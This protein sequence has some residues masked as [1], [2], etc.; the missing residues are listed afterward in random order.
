MYTRHPILKAIALCVVISFFMT[1]LGMTPEAF[2][3]LGV[4]TTDVPSLTAGTLA[5][6]AELG[7][8]TDSVTGDPSA[9]T[10]IH[11]QSA[12]GNYQAEKNIEKL[13]EHI[14]KNSAVRLMLLEGASSKLQPELFRIFPKAP[15][16]N[17]KVTDKLVQEGY[18]T[19]PERFLIENAYG[20]RSTEYGEQNKE[21]GVRNAANIKAEARDAARKTPYAELRTPSAV[22]FDAFGIED[23][24]SYKKDREAFIATVKSGK[25]AENYLQELRVAVDKRFAGKLN[26]DLL[27]LVRQEEA[28]DSGSLSFES[29]LKTLSEASRKH[30]RVDL[31]DA[32]YQDPYPYLIRYDRLQAIGSKIDREK[33]LGEMAGFLNELEKKGI[34]Q[35]VI[36]AFRDGEPGKAENKAESRNA[37]LRTPYSV[38]ASGY[39]PLRH[40]FDAAFE[41]LPKDFSIKA[42]PAWT[43]YA[44][45]VILMQEMEG[46]GLFAEVATLKAKIQETLAKTPEEK[47]YLDAARKLYLLKRLFNLELTRAE[48]EELVT[49]SE[50]RISRLETISNDRKSNDRNKRVSDLKDSGFEFVSDFGIRDSNL[51]EL[52]LLAM[53]FYQTAVIREEHMFSN[54]LKR[55]EELKEKRAIIVTGGFHAE[56]FKQLAAAKGCSYLQITPRIMEVTKRDHEVYL[57]AMLGARQFESSQIQAL[58]GTAAAEELLDVMGVPDL[59]NYMRGVSEITSREI[60]SVPYNQ[61]ILNAFAVWKAVHASSFQGVVSLPAIANLSPQGIGR[62]R[63]SAEAQQAPPPS[64]APSR[65]TDSNAGSSGALALFGGR[66]K[67]SSAALVLFT[68]PV[69]SLLPSFSQYANMTTALRALSKAYQQ[70]LRTH[71]NESTMRSEVRE[72]SSASGSELLALRMQIGAAQAKRAKILAGTKWYQLFA[73]HRAL[74]DLDRTMKFFFHLISR[75]TSQAAPT[76]VAG[77]AQTIGPRKSESGHAQMETYLAIAIASLSIT[78]FSTTHL[79]H[80]LAKEHLV[81]TILGLV[82]GFVGILL[83]VVISLSAPRSTP[84]RSTPLVREEHAARIGELHQL[85]G[86]YT[87][88]ALV[89]DVDHREISAQFSSGGKPWDPIPEAPV[90]LTDQPNE[91]LKR[92]FSSQGIML[93]INW[94]DFKSGQVYYFFGTPGDLERGERL[95]TVEDQTTMKS[96]AKALSGHSENPVLPKLR[97]RQLQEAAGD[98]ASG[99]FEEAASAVEAIAQEIQGTS[100]EEFQIIGTALREILVEIRILSRSSATAHEPGE[101]HRSEI[102]SGREVREHPGAMGNAQGATSKS[103]SLSLPAVQAAV[104][105][106]HARSNA[107]NIMPH[108]WLND[109]YTGIHRADSW[110]NTWSI[111]NNLEHDHSSVLGARNNTQGLVWYAAMKRIEEI[112]PDQ[113]VHVRI[114]L[115]HGIVAEIPVHQDTFKGALAASLYRYL[116]SWAYNL[117][118]IYGSENFGFGADRPEFLEIDRLKTLLEGDKAAFSDVLSTRDP[119]QLKKD[120]PRNGLPKYAN[121]GEPVHVMPIEEMPAM[122]VSAPVAETVNTGS[123]DED[124]DSVYIGADIGGR[125]AKIGV[126]NHEGI[127]ALNKALATMETKTALPES[128]AEFVQR[129]IERLKTIQAQ[130]GKKIRGVGIGIPGAID[131]AHDRPVT[132]GQLENEKG[133]S[134]QDIDQLA[135]M[136]E[137]ISKALGIPRDH[138]IIRNDM[139]PITTAVAANLDKM[140][141]KFADRSKGNFMINWMGSGHGFEISK[142]SAPIP[143]PTEAGHV[144]A[145][146]GKD[147]EPLFDTEGLTSITNLINE[148]RKP[149]WSVP[150]DDLRPLGKAAHD[151]NDPYHAVAIDILQNVFMK[152]FVQNMLMVHLLTAHAGVA[153]TP[154]VLVGGGVTRDPKA[155]ML[156]KLMDE[157]LKQLGLENDLGVHFLTDT[158][159]EAVVKDHSDLGKIGAAYLIRRHIA[160]LS[161]RSEARGM[162]LVDRGLGLM[163][164][165]SQTRTTLHEPL[166]EAVRPELRLTPDIEGLLTL[167]AL[168]L[169]LRVAWWTRRLNDRHEENLRLR[170]DAPGP[171]REPG[172][173]DQFTGHLF[174]IAATLAIEG[175]LLAAARFKLQSGAW[176]RHEEIMSDRGAKVTMVEPRES[177]GFNQKAAILVSTEDGIRGF[178]NAVFEVRDPAEGSR[179]EMRLG[180]GIF[181]IARSFLFRGGFFARQW[182]DERRIEKSIWASDVEDLW[183]KVSTEGPLNTQ[184]A[185]SI[186]REHLRWKLGNAKALVFEIGRKLHRAGIRIGTFR[187]LIE[188]VP[189]EHNS[190]TGGNTEAVKINQE[191]HVYSYPDTKALE[192]ISHDVSGALENMFNLIVWGPLVRVSFERQTARTKHPSRENDVELYADLRP[193]EETKI[194]TWKVVKEVEKLGGDMRDVRKLL[195]VLR[196]YGTALIPGTDTETGERVIERHSFPSATQIRQFLRDLPAHFKRSK[197]STASQGALSALSP[198]SKNSQDVGRKPQAE[199]APIPRRDDR[200]SEVRTTVDVGMDQEVR[201]IEDVYVKVVARNDRTERQPPQYVIQI[202]PARSTWKFI[203][204][205]NL[206]I[207]TK[208]SSPMVTVH[209]SG[210]ETFGLTLSGKHPMDFLVTFTVVKPLKSFRFTVSRSELRTGSNEKGKVVL[211]LVDA[212]TRLAARIA[213]ASTSFYVTKNQVPAIQTRLRE[214]HEQVIAVQRVPP[215][216]WGWKMLIGNEEVYRYF[217]RG[218]PTQMKAIDLDELKVLMATGLPDA[219]QEKFLKAKLIELNK[220]ASWQVPEFEEEFQEFLALERIPGKNFLEQGAPPNINIPALMAFLLRQAVSPATPASV[221][222]PA[223]VASTTQASNPVTQTPKLPAAPATSPITTNQLPP[224]TM[225]PAVPAKTPAPV[226]VVTPTV[227]APVVEAPRS[228]KAPVAPA[229]LQIKRL[230]EEWIPIKNESVL[231]KLPIGAKI[232]MRLADSVTL[233]V[234]SWNDFIAAYPDRMGIPSKPYAAVVINETGTVAEPL[235]EGEI[236]LLGRQPNGESGRVPFAAEFNGAEALSRR[237]LTLQVTSQGL[238]FTD[239]STYGTDLNRTAL[240]PVADAASEPVVGH[241][242][243]RTEEPRSVASEPAIP[244]TVSTAKTPKEIFENLIE[245]AYARGLAVNRNAPKGPAFSYEGKTIQ[246]QNGNTLVVMNVRVKEEGIEGESDKEGVEFA[247]AV[248][249]PEGG[250][251]R[252]KNWTGER[253]FSFVGTG[254]LASM[255]L[256]EK[257]EI[258]ATVSPLFMKRY[259]QKLAWWTLGGLLSFTPWKQDLPVTLKTSSRSEARAGRSNDV[260]RT[261]RGMEL[262]EV[263]DQRRLSDGSTLKVLNFTMPRPEGYEAPL[264]PARRRSV[265]FEYRPDEHS[266]PQELTAVSNQP[267]LLGDHVLTVAHTNLD[268]GLNA[269]V[270]ATVKL[271]RGISVTKIGPRTNIRKGDVLQRLGTITETPTISLRD[272]L[273][274][275]QMGGNDIDVSG[276]DIRYDSIPAGGVVT[277]A[278]TPLFTLIDRTLIQKDSGERLSPMAFFATLGYWKEIKAALRAFAKKGGNEARTGRLVNSLVNGYMSAEFLEAAEAKSF[279]MRSLI[280]DLIN[281]LTEGQFTAA[282]A[283]ANGQLDMKQDPTGDLMIELDAAEAQAPAPG[284]TAGSQQPS[285][286]NRGQKTRSESRSSPNKVFSMSEATGRLFQDGFFSGLVLAAADMV[287]VMVA[288]KIGN[289]FVSIKAFHEFS[290]PDPLSYHRYPIAVLAGITSV[291]DGEGNSM[292]VPLPQRLGVGLMENGPFVV[293]HIARALLAEKNLLEALRTGLINA[294]DEA[295]LKRTLFPEIL[296]TVSEVAG[297]DFFYLIAHRDV[298]WKALDIDFNSGLVY[299][300]VEQQYGIKFSAAELAQMTTPQELVNVT[301]QALASKGARSE[302]RASKKEAAEKA[303]IQK[304]LGTLQGSFAIDSLE[305]KHVELLQTGLEAGTFDSRQAKAKVWEMMQMTYYLSYLEG[306]WDAKRRNLLGVAKQIVGSQIQEPTFYDLITDLEVIASETPHALYGLNDDFT[307]DVRLFTMPFTEAVAAVLMNVSN[308]EPVFKDNHKV[309]A[310]VAHIQALDKWYRGFNPQVS[311]RQTR[312]EARIQTTDHRLPTIDLK[313][314]VSLQSPVSGLRF[315]ESRS[316]VRVA[317]TTPPAY[318]GP[319]VVKGSEVMAQVMKFLPVTLP[320]IFDSGTN[321]VLYLN[322]SLNGRLARQE[323]KRHVSVMI[324][325]SNNRPDI[326]SYLQRQGIRLDEAASYRIALS[327]QPESIDVTLYLTDINTPEREA[328]AQ[329]AIREIENPNWKDIEYLWFDY[330]AGMVQYRTSKAKGWDD[331]EHPN[332]SAAVRLVKGMQ[333]P[334][335]VTVENPSKI[336]A[337]ETA[338][339]ELAFILANPRM[340]ADTIMER[341]L[342]RN[343][344]AVAWNELTAAYTGRRG[345]DMNSIISIVVQTREAANKAPWPLQLIPAESLALGLTSQSRSEA[346]AAGVEKWEQLTHSVPASVPLQ[347][348]TEIVLSLAGLVSLEVLLWDDF[349]KKYPNLAVGVSPVQAVVTNGKDL[350]PLTDQP[351]SLGVETPGKFSD[352]I[353]NPITGDGTYFLSKQHVILKLEQTNLVLIDTSTSGTQWGSAALIAQSAEEKTS[354]LAKPTDTAVPTL[355]QTSDFATSLP[356][357]S[358]SGSV[359]AGIAAQS[360]TLKATAQLAVQEANALPSQT[361][362]LPAPTTKPA[363]QIESAQA[364]LAAFFKSLFEGAKVKYGEEHVSQPSP[365]EGAKWLAAISL[366]GK[367]PEAP[368]FMGFVLTTEEI[369]YRNMSPKGSMI[370]QAGLQESELVYIDDLGNSHRLAAYKD[371]FPVMAFAVHRNTR[372]MVIVDWSGIFSAEKYGS[373]QTPG[374]ISGFATFIKFDA[375]RQDQQLDD[376]HRQYS[377]LGELTSTLPSIPR[378][379]L[380]EAPGTHPEKLG[381]PMNERATAAVQPQTPSVVRIPGLP[382]VAQLAKEPQQL[383]QTIAREAAQPLA[384][385]GNSGAAAKPAASAAQMN[386]VPTGTSGLTLAKPAQ[387]KAHGTRAAGAPVVDDEGNVVAPKTSEKRGFK[388]FFRARSEVRGQTVGSEEYLSVMSPLAEAIGSFTASPNTL[389]GRVRS[390]LRYYNET[391]NVP[392]LS[393]ARHL[394]PAALRAALKVSSVVVNNVTEFLSRPVY[395]AAFFPERANGIVTMSAASAEQSRRAARMALAISPS[396]MDKVLDVFILGKIAEDP[397]VL[398]G[399]CQAYPNVTVVKIVKTQEQRSELRKLNLLLAA[400]GLAPVLAADP[401]NP[402]E[403]RAL[404]RTLRSRG[405]PQVTGLFKGS[406]IVP[407]KLKNLIPYIKV[408]TQRMIDNFRNAVASLVSSLL[409]TLRATAKSA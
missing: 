304:V 26:K 298:T 18:L 44:Q 254:A 191:S 151:E 285:N 317:E 283:I 19:G 81:W 177:L 178:M 354:Q 230:T 145:E 359:N 338:M 397:V 381:V 377:V 217:K 71:G 263:G 21:Y 23:L 6:P 169:L 290:G 160:E 30:L 195:L 260:Q 212:L 75:G 142:N 363:P 323:D 62:I 125:T 343:D 216:W 130:N 229:A 35:E 82:A 404:L 128:G 352:D 42:W 11:I 364:M 16:F 133:W 126:I 331:R 102:R 66:G 342:W 138:V 300:P 340:I 372:D 242:N 248:F 79:F 119:S 296:R 255:N 215:T 164:N 46:K 282:I 246:L 205:T 269:A 276:P 185:E 17:R 78:L 297:L 334:V 31:S 251:L 365:A 309:T 391:V 147:G 86:G 209:Q 74:F 387:V 249:T 155:K 369:E 156:Q 22:Q 165:E 181:T 408:V 337:S 168:G 385:T 239:T 153:D 407:E 294:S 56:G 98:V 382:Q 12:H 224:T 383:E 219:T 265:T 313:P 132:V 99:R 52:I 324:H 350:M 58:L 89:H 4:P 409:Q 271:Q 190:V 54:A 179:S 258:E 374:V 161:G 40:A 252:T 280:P 376:N 281:K 84:M 61:P 277:H 256:G 136:A 306:T 76:P 107:V 295:S 406:E 244:Q 175:I 59:R 270:L 208:T 348:G 122:T 184:H 57:N 157:Q 279:L 360:K 235:N 144:V 25:N 238:V 366:N 379:S 199:S 380:P 241:S 247:V 245:Q 63:P 388:K 335:I 72:D 39:S 266:K 117:G 389:H 344:E 101:P 349:L 65:P 200:R 159:I 192:A 110:S 13:L 189:L 14:E 202:K 401:E 187:M 43:L 105:R 373:E 50:K 211:E 287:V 69:S 356:L 173:F 182:L 108:A 163:G 394:S 330:S 316:E 166:G 240:N 268:R 34:A 186:D 139:E 400:N 231:V 90:I 275:F 174:L 293:G 288:Q 5:I 97:R 196:P 250:E 274:M 123:L 358:A 307:E 328:A 395:V 308:S 402:G 390:E 378:I 339:L 92:M 303:R 273:K 253:S 319:F 367:A 188:D 38:Q 218:I 222:A 143:M 87:M 289:H 214:V 51:E 405:S 60:F 80:H 193:E 403:L 371:A 223:P 291:V 7:Q 305:K 36:Q 272:R 141:Q 329:Q 127:L 135:S 375:F 264:N 104:E 220:L 64:A 357:S 93:T 150:D 262:L 370:F 129:F 115:D 20:V 237:H 327:R 233:N 68:H 29:W 131:I 148:A 162:K 152:N 24:E 347:A 351:L 368:D 213:T 48:Y 345:F 361:L 292:D 88:L 198:G 41:K 221:V 267:V 172:R 176:Q 134:R 67:D 362:R 227:S 140:S 120:R 170:K 278:S 333:A 111:L 113:M 2:A 106:A 53:S 27:S 1:G 100:N 70:T 49:K 85:G 9:P 301:L 137:E 386:V 312:S 95:V 91:P 322:L 399:I 236:L 325:G 259:N 318:E 15:D 94:I 257:G 167:G 210:D 284:L 3:A 47:E 194:L 398:V 315:D 96:L 103:F 234:L 37:V 346:R 121:L 302:A 232:G 311:A 124:A 243:K 118:V 8:V 158:E 154:F 197:T 384:A 353:R 225:A 10:F 114:A 83:A 73:R 226:L 77:K 207:G 206:A 321:K 109:F 204:R 320:K 392:R 310:I 149:G 201:L 146:F 171:Q 314:A 326:E 180:A 286:V 116:A 203:S 396:T 228:I 393:R 183:K 341:R 355:P 55:M 332:S 299:Q 32:Y 28:F 112:A 261:W 33:A 45:H 336:F